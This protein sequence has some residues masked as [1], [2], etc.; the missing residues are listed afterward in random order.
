MNFIMKLF[1]TSTYTYF[2]VFVLLESTTPQSAQCGI[3]RIWVHSQYRRKK[4]ATRLLDCVRTNFIYGCIIPRELVAFSDP[5][6]D[7]KRLANS[8]AGTSQF[9][10]FR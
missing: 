10:V 4:V 7:G 5:T 6:P 1:C 3:S 9:L 8:Y 2:F